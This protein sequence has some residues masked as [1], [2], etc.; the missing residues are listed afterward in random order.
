MPP[1]RVTSLAHQT[2]LNPNSSSPKY[3]DPAFTGDFTEAMTVR[4][5]P[6]F[7][8]LRLVRSQ[9]SYTARECALRL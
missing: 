8:L 5:L 1:H 7:S 2:V 4:S 3:S 6:Y 9:G